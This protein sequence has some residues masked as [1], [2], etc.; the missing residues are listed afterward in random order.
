MLTCREI[1]ELLDLYLDQELDTLT[2]ER[3]AQHLRHCPRCMALLQSKEDEAELIRGCFPTPQLPPD[4]SNGVMDKLSA[5]TARTA[6]KQEPQTP[7]SN[8]LMK[9]RMVPLIAAALLIFVFVETYSAG[10]LP[11]SPQNKQDAK[12]EPYIQDNVASD[13]NAQLRNDMGGFGDMDGTDSMDSKTKSK[14]L[15]SAIP[16]FTPGYLPQGF[17]QE[18]GSV[19]GNPGGEKTEESIFYTYRNP[20]TGASINLQITR[21]ASEATATNEARAAKATEVSFFAE[22]DGEHYLIRLSGDVSSD[23][24][25]KIASSLK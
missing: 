8:I 1:E 15:S 22:K 16:D 10:L 13:N 2:R 11:L 17:I 25:K 23:E 5:R 18:S 14:S 24:L 7:R 3:C 12:R 6:R 21:V 9:F 19:A 20:Q 4:F